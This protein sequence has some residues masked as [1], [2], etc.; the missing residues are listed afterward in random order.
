MS[1]TRT[2]VWI[3]AHEGRDLIRADAIVMLR[4]DETGRL[5][6]Q[7][8]DQPQV[9]VALLEGTALRRPPADFHRQLIR[10]VSQLEDSSGA[11]VVHASLGTDGW[12]WVSEPL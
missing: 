2:E 11:R 8:H 10:T 3:A 9:S 5:T 7:L 6:A 12:R 1:G 4:F